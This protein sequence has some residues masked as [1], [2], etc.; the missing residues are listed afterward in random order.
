MIPT[1]SVVGLTFSVFLFV[2]SFSLLRAGRLSTSS[3][4]LWILI[5]VGLGISLGLPMVLNEIFFALGTQLLLSSVLAVAFLMLLVLILHL[6]VKLDRVESQMLKTTAELSA[7]EY[8]RNLSEDEPHRP[9]HSE[10]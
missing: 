6:N 2:L 1:Y 5:S 10:S 7:L 9:N 8:T 3:F 4:Y